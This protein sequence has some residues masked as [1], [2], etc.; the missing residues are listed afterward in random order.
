MTEPPF[1][2]TSCHSSHSSYFLPV[3]LSW[4][5]NQCLK[6]PGELP[7]IVMFFQLNGS[8]AQLFSF[9]PHKEKQHGILDEADTL[10]QGKNTYLNLNCDAY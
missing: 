5:L 10:K 9:F 6:K 8:H 2:N 3:A 4:Y 7:T 1:S